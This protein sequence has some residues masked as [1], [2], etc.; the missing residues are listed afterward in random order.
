MFESKIPCMTAVVAAPKWKLWPKYP[1]GSLPMTFIAL[2]SLAT[3]SDRV[4]DF[5]GGTKDLVHSHAL[6]SRIIEL[7]LD[8]VYSE[9]SVGR[10]QSRF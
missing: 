3:K 6:L 7:P 4:K 10:Y 2:F 5:L 9:F 1:D 8:V